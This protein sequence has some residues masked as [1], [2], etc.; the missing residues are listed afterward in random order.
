LDT[1]EVHLVRYLS[2]L[3]FVLGGPVA[4][5]AVRVDRMSFEDIGRAVEAGTYVGDHKVMWNWPSEE[6]DAGRL[7]S[8]GAPFIAEEDCELAAFGG[9]PC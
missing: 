7:A 6:H 8:R 9:W 2:F 3:S 4:P 1:I 5:A